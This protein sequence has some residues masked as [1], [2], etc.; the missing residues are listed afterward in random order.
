M[1]DT[2]SIPAGPSSKVLRAPD[3]KKTRGKTLRI[4]IC[5]PHPDDEALVGGLALRLHQESG[6]KVTTVAITL[7]SDLIQRRRRLRELKAS[8]S[9]LGFRLVVANPPLGFDQVRIE[10]RRKH[11]T[12]WA[13]K[14]KTL[15][16]VFERE[17]PDVVFVHHAEDENTTH[18]ATHHLVAEALRKYLRRAGCDSIPVIEMEYWHQLSSPNLMV[19]IS[20]DDEATLW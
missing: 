10:S 5:S 19:G 16:G 4:V 13:K 20:P 18:V 12:D 15:R 8:C 11:P 14:V 17:M 1:E 9:A 6:A 7:G 3:A 2:K